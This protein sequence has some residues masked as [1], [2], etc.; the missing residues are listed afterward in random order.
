MEKDGKLRMVISNRERQHPGVVDGKIM[1]RPNGRPPGM[2]F[3]N[4]QGN[5]AGGL[6]FDENGGNGHFLQLTFDKSRQD[7]TLG[8]RH[9][10]SDNGQYFAGLQ[11]WDRPHNSLA[12]FIT[13]NE[14]IQKMPNGSEKDAAMRSLA[15]ENLSPQRVLI[16]KLRDKSATVELSDAQG[17]PR[18]RMSVGETGNPRLEFLD[19]TGKVTHRLPDQR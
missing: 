8:L 14:I 17:K 5:E 18:I 11:I 6:I 4:H 19:E 9:L 15:A 13:R 10:E 16:G 2:I 7:Q 3:F 12:D 1:P